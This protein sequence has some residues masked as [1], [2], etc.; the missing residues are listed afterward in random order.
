MENK[1]KWCSMSYK[2]CKFSLLATHIKWFAMD[3]FSYICSHIW[4]Q[5][6]ERL[7]YTMSGTFYLIWR[8]CDR[9]SWCISIVKPTRCTVFEFIEYH[10]TCFR[11]SFRPSSGVQDCTYSIR[12]MSNR[13]CWLLASGHEMDCRS[14]SCPLASSQLTCMT[15]TWC[16]VY[17]LELLIMDGKTVWNM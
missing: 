9:A 15:Y 16:C 13:F 10:S 12:H 17:S 4:T 5:V 3:V 7:L 14:I 6:F 2:F 8:S 1:A 11:Q